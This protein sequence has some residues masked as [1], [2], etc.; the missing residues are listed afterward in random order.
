MNLKTPV[1]SVFLVGPIYAKKLK[2]LGIESIGDLLYH[3]PFRYV[4]YSLASKIAAI[5]PG[6]VITIAGFVVY[7]KNE[8]TR[9][10]FNLQKIRIKDETGEIEAVWFNQPFL[11]K[12]FRLGQKITLSGKA[13]KF[14]GKLVLSSPDYEITGNRIHTGRL[15]P[16][17]H[18]TAG[19]TSRWLRSRIAHLMDKNDLEI[20]DFLPFNNLP[21]LKQALQ[22]RHFPCNKQEAK[23]A[24]ERFAFEELFLIQLAILERKQEWQDKKPAYVLKIDEKINKGFINNLPFRLTQAQERS[25]G[26]ILRDLE[27]PKPMNRLLE[28]DVGSGKTVVAATAILAAVKNKLQAG[29]M[30]PT[31]IL[32]QQHYE[33]LTKLLGRYGVK[34][35]LVTG[36]TKH[37]IGH[38]TADLII[39]TQALLHRPACF[40]R[41]AL[42]VVDEQH[43]FGVAQRNKLLAKKIIPH[44]LTMTA[45]PIP[46]SIA[47][48]LYGDL[49]LSVI[50]EMPKKRRK[51]KTWLIPSIKRTAAYEWIKKQIREQKSQVFVICPL[52][53]ASE[54]ESMQSIKAV[55]GEFNELQKIF[56]D[57]RLA[58]LHGRLKST[59]KKEILEK[60]RKRESDIL[61]S[62]P[63]VEVG[64]DIPSA[65][66]MLVE[67]AERFGLAQLHQL[68]GRV[69]R[70]TSQA[71]C[72]LFTSEDN[73]S[74]WQRLKAVEK[75]NV[76]FELAEIDL[77]QRGAG[78][79]YGLQ[80]HGFLDLKNAS[81]TNIKMIKKAQ[82]AAEKIW[83]KL[84]NF[85]LLKEKLEEG[86]MA[87]ISQN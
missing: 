68:R 86:K 66:I 61:V 27:K 42:L 31:E 49:D 43:R 74:G 25:I 16:V 70:G 72:L 48:T 63:V 59:E 40:H 38:Q 23:E 64:I 81:L 78:E 13:E 3:F 36:G 77:R 76:G 22:W 30:A 8:Y 53:E 29:L 14:G 57:F 69:G 50:D 5:Q 60:F 51:V 10:N 26:E 9:K 12:N 80:Q 73:Q 32:A 62:T 45:T 15:V 87:L 18:E 44:L 7:A 20:S 56:S 84:K 79:I 82:E 4:D 17:Y 19:I 6:E 21:E 65:T 35:E 24:E 28:G 85:P 34:I 2:R 41:L 39:G 37:G 1:S 58:L 47:L 54:K 71:Y 55:K 75:I 11:I 52:I 46:R 67:G 33:T 83:P